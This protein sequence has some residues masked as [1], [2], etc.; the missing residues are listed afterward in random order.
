[1]NCRNVSRV[2]SL[3]SINLF[4]GFAMALVLAVSPAEAQ[5]KVM[6]DSLLL[7]DVTAELEQM[8]IQDQRYR[9]EHDPVFQTGEWNDSLEQWVWQ[10]QITIDAHNIARLDTLIEAH[11]WMGR[12]QIGDTGVTAVFLIVQHADI[13][14]LKKYLP[15]MK[16]SADSGNFPLKYPAYVEDRLRMYQGRP[17]LYGT[18]V[19]IDDATGDM[20]LYQ[21]EDEAHVDERRA[22]VGLGPLAEYLKSMGLDRKVPESGD[23]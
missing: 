19:K 8:R 5:G 15:M 18:Q 12:R 7:P 13:D 2:I 20:V 1:M 3:L 4:A 9:G 22:A 23:Q 6:K 11:G 14:H 10:Q 21:V 16:A 17:Q